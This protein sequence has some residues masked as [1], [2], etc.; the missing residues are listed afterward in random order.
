MINFNIP[1]SILGILAT[2]FTLLNIA[3]PMDKLLYVIRV[4]NTEC[5][6]FPLILM[7]LVVSTLWA[8]YGALSDDF[9]L[10]V[11]SPYLLFRRKTN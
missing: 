7:S 4:K 11:I 6:P 2:I 3:S 5:L 9:F 10:T 8:I 1:F